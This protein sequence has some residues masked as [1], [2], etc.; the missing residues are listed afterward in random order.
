M[1]SAKK[2]APPQTDLPPWLLPEAP[3]GSAVRY[4]AGAL[5]RLMR[6]SI[7]IARGRRKL[8][9]PTLGEGG[10][11]LPAMP[12]AASN[13]KVLGWLTVATPQGEALSPADQAVVRR[14]I[15]ELGE[16]WLE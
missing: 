7:A 8:K 9:G 14:V 12:I 13:G 1:K 6:V 3:A 11:A 10:K 5:P 16:K 2:V 4:L 15:T